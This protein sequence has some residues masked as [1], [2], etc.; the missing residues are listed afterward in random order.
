MTGLAFAFTL[1]LV[2]VNLHHLLKP[3]QKD[4]PA[5]THTRYKEVVYHVGLLPGVCINIFFS[6]Q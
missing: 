5:G 3:T 4:L 1:V 6:N 2:V